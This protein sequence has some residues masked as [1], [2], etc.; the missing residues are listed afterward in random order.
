MVLCIM[1]SWAPMKKSLPV[2]AVSFLVAGRN[3][4]GPNTVDRLFNVILLVSLILD[5]LC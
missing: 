5:I 3:R 2:S 4:V 1:A